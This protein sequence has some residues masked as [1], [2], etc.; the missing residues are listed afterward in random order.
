MCARMRTR[1]RTQVSKVAHHFK[2][3]KIQFVFCSLVQ[4]NYM[5]EDV[6]LDKDTAPAF[7]INDYRTDKKWP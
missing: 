3:S 5:L 1:A 4:L 2:G 7:A 6:G